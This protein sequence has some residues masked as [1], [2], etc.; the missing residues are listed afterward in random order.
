MED[1]FN[2][3][4]EWDYNHSICGYM[5]YYRT[6]VDIAIRTRVLTIWARIVHSRPWYPYLAGIEEI[7]GT[8]IK[9]L[10]EFT[11]CQIPKGPPVLQ[12]LPDVPFPRL[13][14]WPTEQVG[15]LVEGTRCNPTQVVL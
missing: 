6:D 1:V 14:A 10:E 8:V 7:R 9:Y 11:M 12:V 15:Q 4:S 13:H 3:D 5:C 2:G